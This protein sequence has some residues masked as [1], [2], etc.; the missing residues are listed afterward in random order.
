MAACNNITSSVLV[1]VRAS[2]AK[3]S[4]GIFNGQWRSDGARNNS[5]VTANRLRSYT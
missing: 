4:S 5:R 1:V 3:G 2:K